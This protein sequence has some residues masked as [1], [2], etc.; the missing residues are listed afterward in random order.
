MKS[1]IKQGTEQG[2]RDGKM[3]KVELPAL[4]GHRLVHRHGQYQT[5]QA[6][7]FSYFSWKQKSKSNNF[8]VFSL[9]T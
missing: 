4:S 9:S 1:T 3:N 5:L 7:L 6:N 8:H 2:W